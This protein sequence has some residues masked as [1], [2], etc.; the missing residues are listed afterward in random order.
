MTGLPQQNLN[1]DQTLRVLLVE[2]NPGDARLIEKRLEKTDCPLL[3]A[4]VEVVRAESL[5]EAI[6]VLEADLPDAMLLDLG[7]PESRG[8]AT[9][10]RMDAYIN[11]LP[12]IVLT[13][14]DDN[15]VAVRAVRSGAQDYLH[16]DGIDSTK[17][18]RALRYAFERQRVQR[19][20]QTR[21]SE[22]DRII[23]LGTLAAGT[24]HE[25]N[26]PLSYLTGNVE[27]ALRSL[28]QT[29]KGYELPAEVA[30][31][32]DDACDALRDAVDGGKRVRD[33][34]RDLRKLAGSGREEADFS[35]EMVEVNE[36]LE[37]S[38][39]IAHN[40]LAT[41]ARVVKDLGQVP[42]VLGN[43]SKL[44]QV[45]LNLLINA[46]QAIPDDTPVEDHEIR[47]A[48]HAREAHVVVEIADTGVGIPEENLDRLFE[49]FFSTK[50]SDRGTGLGLAICHQ[51][52]SAMDGRIEVETKVGEGSCFRVILPIFDHL[53]EAPTDVEVEAPPDSDGD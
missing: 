52:I 44:G 26:N 22:M 35:I 30:E 49:P 27:Y 51:I 25:I 45:F 18:A 42:P 10:E 31:R 9:L 17:L 2:D 1:A 48:S 12:I 39:S 7:L 32:L 5:T 24:A 53:G 14:L 29:M 28:E 13:G 19:E 38:L 16:K 4:R 34:V 33:V 37:S 46:A 6:S 41:H 3:A 20:V 21:I 8:I 23:T 11:K 36:A 43:E 15:D 50:A 47:V 40:R